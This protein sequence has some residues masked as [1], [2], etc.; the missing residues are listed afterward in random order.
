MGN[1]P[2]LTE[3]HRS[4]LTWSWKSFTTN[5]AL[6]ISMSEVHRLLASTARPLALG[7][8]PGKRVAD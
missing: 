3:S 1:G 5:T 4:M 8:P 2:Q 6:A 7:T